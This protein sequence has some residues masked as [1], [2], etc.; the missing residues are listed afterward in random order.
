MFA[1]HRISFCSDTE[2][3]RGNGWRIVMSFVPEQI[4]LHVFMVTEAR[5]FIQL[6]HTKCFT[7]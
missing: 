6:V 5:H 4:S 1:I 2:N 3:Y 7:F